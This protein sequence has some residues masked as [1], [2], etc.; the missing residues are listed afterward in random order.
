MWSYKIPGKYILLKTKKNQVVLKW[1]SNMSIETHFDYESV[2]LLRSQ[3]RLSP[4][5][6]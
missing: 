1:K 5:S 2:P 6:I 3:I 4:V